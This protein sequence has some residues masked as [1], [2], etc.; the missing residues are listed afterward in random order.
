MSTT[1]ETQPLPLEIQWLRLRTKD[2]EEI[3][4]DLLRREAEARDE[5]VHEAQTRQEESVLYEAQIEELEAREVGLDVFAAAIQEAHERAHHV[6]HWESC[7]N[8]VCRGLEEWILRARKDRPP[9]DDG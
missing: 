3:I 8:L 6:G 5:A 1:D 4:R 9:G 7:P 2:P